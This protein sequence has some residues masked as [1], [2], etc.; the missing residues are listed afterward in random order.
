MSK[1]KKKMLITLVLFMLISVNISFAFWASNI[2]GNGSVAT[3]DV[4]LGKWL[5]PGF[6]AV[7]S[8][9]IGASITL[10]EIGTSQYPTSGWYMMIEDIDFNNQTFNPIANFEGLFYGNGYVISNINF[11]T[12]TTQIGLFQTI[13]SSGLV[14]GLN[15]FNASINHSGNADKTAGLIAGI[16]QGTIV[17]S[18]ATGIVNLSLSR[19]ASAGTNN[20]TAIAGG[21]VGQNQGLLVDSYANV[22]VTATTSLTGGFFSTK[23]ATS[24]GGGLVGQTSV[25]DGIVRTYA[26]GQVTSNATST[27]GFIVSN[28]P[29][30]FGGGLVGQS[31][32]VNQIVDSFSTGNVNSN[33]TA[34]SGAV[35]GSGGSTNSYRLNTQTVNGVS[36]TGLSAT[37]NELRSSS[38][39]STHL[40]FLAS[41]W[42]FT[43]TAY[44]TIEIE[45]YELYD[46]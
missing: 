43:T 39:L 21:L 10:D 36:G 20:L 34:N 45:L 41:R 14:H 18:S 16:N 11:S 31:G 5:P 22:S 28:N 15:L 27:G 42:S 46:G 37:I 4:S 44:P 40:G 30:A 24:Y 6:I 35:V 13:T 12:S 2:L 3:G 33:P 32:G 25:I 19:G 9:G 29:I 38:F 17:Y 23:N 7:S 26:N 1:Q 8:D